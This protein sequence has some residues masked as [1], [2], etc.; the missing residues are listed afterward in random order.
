MVVEQMIKKNSG[1]KKSYI[2]ELIAFDKLNVVNENSK[3]TKK[4][5]RVKRLQ[6][7]IP[8]LIAFIKS[9]FFIFFGLIFLI[10]F[11]GFI[12]WLSKW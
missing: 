12:W 3:N 1:H 8:E 10:L 6:L 7:L 9:F 5:K 11:G 4:D 2:P